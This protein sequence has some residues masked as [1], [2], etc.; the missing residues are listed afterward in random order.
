MRAPVCSEAGGG[1]KHGRDGNMSAKHVV[2]AYDFSD[3]A[4]RALRTAFS[5]TSKLGSKL[6]VVH[7]HPELYNGRG[8]PDLGLPWPGA[9]QEDRYLRFLQQELR[10][11]VVAELGKDGGGVP[12]RVGRGDVVLQLRE[13]GKELGADL[14]CVGAANKTGLERALL[15]SVSEALVR[16]SDTPVL[17]VR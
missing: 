11:E 14:I 10:N 7:I 15:G 2:V 16:S 3:A 1:R 6:S 8:N 17:T 13:L 5:L 4:R 12:V 9:E